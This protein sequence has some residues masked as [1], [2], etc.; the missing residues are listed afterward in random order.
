M[1]V[2]VGDEPNERAET[3]AAPTGIR[4]EEIRPDVSFMRQLVERMVMKE[5]GTARSWN[6]HWSSREHAARTEAQEQSLS[7]APVAALIFDL[8]GVPGRRWGA[9]SFRPA[10]RPAIGVF[11][12]RVSQLQ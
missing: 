9:M 3:V 5:N 2:R 8:S 10:A 6:Q 4:V 1:E 11:G 12:Q 7:F